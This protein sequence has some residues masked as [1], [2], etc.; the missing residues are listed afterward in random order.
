MNTIPMQQGI[1]SVHQIKFLCHFLVS[2]VAPVIASSDEQ[3]NIVRTYFAI[4]DHKIAYK[5]SRVRPCR[6]DD[7]E[8]IIKHGNDGSWVEL[9]ESALVQVCEKKEK[10]ESPSVNEAPC[11][12]QRPKKKVALTLA[13]KGCAFL[14]FSQFCS[15]LRVVTESCSN[16][17][18]SLEVELRK[19]SPS[20]QRKK[21]QRKTEDLT[22][23]VNIFDFSPNV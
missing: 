22:F 6:E 12:K 9:D 20:G 3:R 18:H 5:Y 13:C 23:R 15:V 8:A 17:P 11:H 21:L 4:S 14:D 2:R 7:A 16:L 10:R 1:P 19:T